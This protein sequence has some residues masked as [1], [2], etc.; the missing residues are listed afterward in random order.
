MYLPGLASF[1]HGR[2][3]PR[4]F[5]DISGKEKRGSE[6]M[7]KTEKTHSV[8]VIP[9]SS[10]TYYLHVLQITQLAKT[11]DLLIQP[12]SWYIMAFYCQLMETHCMVGICG[13]VIYSV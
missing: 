7:E 12:Y 9:V 4:E 1:F 11:T 6:E 2:K 5:P 13:D 10:Y 8:L 3:K